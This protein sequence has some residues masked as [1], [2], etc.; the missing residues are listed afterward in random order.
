M[1][2][3]S[4]LLFNEQSS[5]NEQKREICSCSKKI[6]IRKLEMNIQ[7][8]KGHAGFYVAVFGPKER[9][10]TRILFDKKFF[11]PGSRHGLQGKSRMPMPGH[12]DP[13]A[14]EDAVNTKQVQP[15]WTPR[16]DPAVKGREARRRAALTASC[17]MVRFGLFRKSPAAFPSPHGSPWPRARDRAVSPKIKEEP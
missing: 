16:M 15:G 17:L 1:L 4:A 9:I 8:K 5:W 10:T 7:Q 3:R 6:W 11:C 13:W 12:V 14:G 2:F